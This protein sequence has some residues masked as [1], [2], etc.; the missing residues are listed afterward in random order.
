[1]KN[2]SM[3]QTQI[4]WPKLIFIFWLFCLFL[5]AS[6]NAFGQNPVIS[7]TKEGEKTH[8]MMSQETKRQLLECKNMLNF[9][10]S[11]ERFYAGKSYQLAWVAKSNHNRQLAPAMLI[12]DC[13]KQYGLTRDNFH[14]NN[15]LYKQIEI[16]A[17]EPEML[18]GSQRAI[19]DVLMTDAMLTFMNYLHYGQFNASLTPLVVDQGKLGDFNAVDKLYTLM[20]SKDFYN[21]IASVQPLSKE[22]DEL[23]KYMHLVRGQYL[24][25]S[26]EFP[27]KSVRKMTI[28]MERLRWSDAKPGPALSINIPAQTAKLHILHSVKEFKVIVGKPSSPTPT[29]ISRITHFTTAPEWKVPYNIFVNELLPKAIRDRDYLEN[30]HFA[31]Y[32]AKGNYININQKKLAYIKAHPKSYSAR[33]ASGCENAMGRLVF[34]FQNPYQ[35]FLHDTPQPKLFLSKNRALSHGCIRVEN[36][37][38]L[39]AMILTADDSRSKIPMMRKAIAGYQKKNFVL[40]TPLPIS[41]DYIT[42]VMSDS[43]LVIFEDIYAQDRALEMAMYGYERL[44]ASDLKISLKAVSILP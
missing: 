9:P 23:Q 44:L 38:T 17:Q 21:D 31:I 13:V 25:D 10:E 26:Y 7:F 34:R 32:D 19:F 6:I 43:Q 14:G 33:Q 1:M 15:L 28:N 39:A 30:N 5:H 27:E 41:V 11:V 42:C 2:Q 29:L 16:F 22:Y 35:V 8:E 37:E 20:E 12:L 4:K 3:V 24:E 36:I 40:I 18:S